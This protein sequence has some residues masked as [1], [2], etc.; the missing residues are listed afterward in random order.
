MLVALQ[1]LVSPHI[2]V[3]LPISNKKVAVAAMVVVV[4][5]HVITAMFGESCSQA[6][7]MSMCNLLLSAAEAACLAPLHGC[8]PTRTGFVMAVGRHQVE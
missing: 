6:L 8:L 2:E 7:M 4:A 5:G 3:M 1:L